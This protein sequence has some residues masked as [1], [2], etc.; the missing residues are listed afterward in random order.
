MSGTPSYNGFVRE[1]VFAKH[2]F[3]PDSPLDIRPGRDRRDNRDPEK[4][5]SKIQELVAGHYATS[6]SFCHDLIEMSR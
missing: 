4:L 5:G 2:G 6:A 3:D 1:D